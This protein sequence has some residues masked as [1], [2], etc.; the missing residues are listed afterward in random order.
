MW[1]D[2]N[3]IASSAGE[4]LFFL[5]WIPWITIGGDMNHDLPLTSHFF[6]NSKQK[7]I[8]TSSLIQQFQ[9]IS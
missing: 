6:Q 4:E 8:E 5:Q 7:M 3:V 1:D 2:K 9:K